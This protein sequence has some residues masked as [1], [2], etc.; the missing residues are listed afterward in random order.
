M[1][2]VRVAAGSNIYFHKTIKKSEAIRRN[3]MYCNI[4]WWDIKTEEMIVFLGIL[5]KFLLH[6]IDGGGYPAYFRSTNKHVFISCDKDDGGSFIKIC[7]TTGFAATYM[8]L[9]R[10][11]QICGTFHPE[12]KGVASRGADKCYQLRH[13][14]STFNAAST[15]IVR[16]HTF[17]GD[18]HKG[19]EKQKNHK[20]YYNNS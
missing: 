4:R 19:N 18:N 3:N 14:I 12:N 11:Q 15:N 16:K 13:L 9:Q 2:T 5:L 7:Q 6:P 8:S 10:F 20:D 17:N 1:V